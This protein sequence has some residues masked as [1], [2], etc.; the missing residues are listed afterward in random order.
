MIHMSTLDQ[1][2][3]WLRDG[4]REAAVVLRQWLEPVEGKGSVIFPPTYTLE[5]TDRARSYKDGK[6]PSG[7][8]QSSQGV[9]GYNIDSFRDGSNV[10]QIDSV[11][12]QAN[13]MEPIFKNA[14]YMHLVPQYV[15]STG[16]EKISLLDV[17]HRAADAIVRFSDISDKLS[18]AFK[19]TARGDARG[20]AIIAPTSLVFGFW[21]SRGTQVKMPRIV[22]S[23]IR[24]FDVESL[25]RSAQ[26]KPP[27]EY[28]EAGLVDKVSNKSEKDA[29]SK[30][31]LAHA[32]APM[33]HGGILVRGEIRRD[34]SLN[35][36]AI[37]SLGAGN[38]DPLPLRRY[39]LGL[40]LVAL[41][42]PQ[43]DFLREGCHLVVDPEHKPQ[44]NIVDHDGKRS[45]AQNLKHEQVLEFASHAAKEFGVQ[46]GEVS[47]G[48][49]SK[50]ANNALH[51]SGD[52]KKR[53]NKVEK[54][55]N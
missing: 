33:S 16:D 25:H 51:G 44:W 50:K 38:D 36:V 5:D 2:D 19:A 30:Q 15:I 10:C 4:G 6:S 27:V 7:V 13:H 37:R 8:Y 54:A 11:G 14:G 49:D 23:V 29:L 12:S 48:F 28:E 17:G 43:K 26:Y 22:R 39:I 31:G 47:V 20:L 3:E 42:A 9:Y 46:Q 35:L 24:A 21:D 55:S 40:S 45:D 52:G 41:T 34:A 32:P 53:P 18:S 1:Y